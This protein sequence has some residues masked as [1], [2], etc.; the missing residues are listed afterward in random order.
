VPKNPTP[1]FYIRKKNNPNAETP[2]V[3]PFIGDNQEEQNPVDLE[4]R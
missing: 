2:K 3:P 1:E 4:T